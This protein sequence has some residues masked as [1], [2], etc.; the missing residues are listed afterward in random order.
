MDTS[1]RKH[2]T[3]NSSKNESAQLRLVVCYCNI[4]LRGTLPA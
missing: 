4:Q 3:E 1:G 2:K